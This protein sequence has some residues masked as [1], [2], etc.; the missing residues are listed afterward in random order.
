MAN[1]KAHTAVDTHALDDIDSEYHH[2]SKGDSLL[3]TRQSYKPASWA[4][5]WAWELITCALGIAAFAAIVATL[6]HYDGKPIPSLP[7]GATVGT[8]CSHNQC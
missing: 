6:K 8:K 7:G 3:E 4:Y 2:D 1:H 5:G